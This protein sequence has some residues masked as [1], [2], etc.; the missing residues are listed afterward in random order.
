MKLHAAQIYP[1]GSLQALLQVVTNFLLSGLTFFLASGQSTLGGN[2]MNHTFG[3][4][5]LCI[6]LRASAEPSCL[7]CQAQ[8]QFRFRSFIG[9]TGYSIGRVFDPVVTRL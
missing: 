9:H 1:C 2:D 3:F 4:V 6:L 5:D 8:K 7:V